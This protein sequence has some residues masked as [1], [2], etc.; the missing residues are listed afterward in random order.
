LS[1][2]TV[3]DVLSLDKECLCHISFVFAC[4]DTFWCNTPYWSGNL[5]RIYSPRMPY[6][7]G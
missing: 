2:Q 6:E 1:H 5:Y 7:I 4:T 3:H